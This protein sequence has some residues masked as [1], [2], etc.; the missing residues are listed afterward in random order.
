MSFRHS[1]FHGF[2]LLS[3]GISSCKKSSNYA[4]VEVVGHAGA[5]LDV[6]RVPFPGNTQQSLDFAAGLGLK[7]VEVDLQLSADHQL[8]MFHNDFLQGQTDG[9]G[10]IR[11]LTAEQI[12]K[13]RYLGFPKISVQALREINFSAFQQVFL[14]IRHYNACE[15]FNLF[16]FALMVPEIEELRVKF[17]SQEFVV[18]S[19]YIP[20]LLLFKDLG[21]EVCQEVTEMPAI[22]NSYNNFEIDF[23]IIRNL[24]I[25]A[26][27]VN[28]ARKLG[29]RLV[30][31]G[32]KSHAGNRDAMRK[33]P[34][35]VMT[36]A[37]VSALQL[38]REK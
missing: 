12:K 38:T 36:D 27:Q 9:T 4:H 32:V 14:D 28:E 7:H 22:L 20:L 25:S 3:V 33:N 2:I 1:V 11:N 23:F 21:F 13:M 24:N 6:E 35:F 5:G 29:V 15:D 10:C 16:D 30:I 8:I 19:R 37:I 34:T 18:V 26:E 31:Y 17:P